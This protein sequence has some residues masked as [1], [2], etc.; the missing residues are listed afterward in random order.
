M[1]VE[2]NR[3]GQNIPLDNGPVPVGM[4]AR[5]KEGYSRMEG[6]DVRWQTG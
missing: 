5:F 2:V 3:T 6:N 1:L 4:K